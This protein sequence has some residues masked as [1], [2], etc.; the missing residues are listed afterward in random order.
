MGISRRATPTATREQ[1]FIVNAALSRR[2]APGVFSNGSSNGATARS[3]PVAEV[4]AEPVPVARC[5]L[6]PTELAE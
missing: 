4:T 6:G 1:F 5:L 3:G 2:S